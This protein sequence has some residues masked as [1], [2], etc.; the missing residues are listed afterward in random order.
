MAP[1]TCTYHGSPKNSETQAPSSTGRRAELTIPMRRAKRTPT[2][3]F[4][5][6]PGRSMTSSSGRWT[7]RQ[8][9]TIVLEEAALSTVSR[10][11]PPQD[12]RCPSLLLWLVSRFDPLELVPNESRRKSFRSG[13]I[14]NRLILHLRGRI[15]PHAVFI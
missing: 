14:F 8:P 1:T 9:I 7:T 4:S 2:T 13:K 12:P 6:N 10:H 5:T 3:T 11:R 15:S